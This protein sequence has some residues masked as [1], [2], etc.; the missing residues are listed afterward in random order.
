MK[1]IIFLLLIGISA[2]H[3]QYKFVEKDTDASCIKYKIV[4]QNNKEVA[5]PKK[6]M[7]ILSCPSVAELHQNLLTYQ[8]G[9]AIKQYNLDTK[10]EVVL[11]KVYHDIDGVSDPVWSDDHSKMM[12]VIINQEKRYGYKDMCR[13]LVL[14]ISNGQILKKWKYDRPVNFSCG[15][16]CSSSGYDDF[17][18]IDTKTIKYKRNINIEDRPGEFETIILE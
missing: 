8:D 12:F 16:L 13:I 15:S 3:A 2:I 18:F 4:D 5:L 6:I 7:E 9:I 10:K 17:M 11:F 14:E 1:K